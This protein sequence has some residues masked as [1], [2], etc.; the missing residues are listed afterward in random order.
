MT[1]CSDLQTSDSASV[2]SVLLPPPRMEC[3]LCLTSSIPAKANHIQKTYFLIASISAHSEYAATKS[4]FGMN[5]C[6]RLGS[7]FSRLKL[8]AKCLKQHFI[9]FCCKNIVVVVCFTTLVV[10]EISQKRQND[11]I[12]LPFRNIPDFR[13][14]NLANYGIPLASPLPKQGCQL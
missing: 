7:T 5:S 13:R 12:F 8:L 11:F 14:I 3:V 9:Q 6:V 2:L 10:N 4:A 1:T